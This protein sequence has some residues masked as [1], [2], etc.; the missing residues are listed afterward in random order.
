MNSTSAYFNGNSGS[1]NCSLVLRILAKLF[2]RKDIY[3]TVLTS[4]KII[5]KCKK[6]QCTEGRK[7]YQKLIR[8]KL[9]E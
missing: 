1:P 3:R 5:G 7:V 8:R 4:K 9:H 6:V 2:Y